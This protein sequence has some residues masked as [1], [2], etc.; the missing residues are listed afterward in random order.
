LSDLGHRDRGSVTG[1]RAVAGTTDN[2]TPTAVDDVAA[3]KEDA[4]PNQVV[5]NVLSNDQ[6]AEALMALRR[7]SGKIDWK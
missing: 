6:D 1:R 4:A 5:G 7:E 2:S 3:I